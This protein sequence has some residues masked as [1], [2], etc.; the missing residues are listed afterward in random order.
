MTD[1]EEV[2][3][4][5]AIHQFPSLQ[6]PVELPLDLSRVF[7]LAWWSSD[8]SRPAVRGQLPSDDGIAIYCSGSLRQASQKGPAIQIG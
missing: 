7:Q 5:V 2:F 3:Q 8:D 1:F 6:A 4:A